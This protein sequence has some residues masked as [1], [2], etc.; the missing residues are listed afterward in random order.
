VRD[1]R[2][3]RVI[4]CVG[5]LRRI[6]QHVTSRKRSTRDAVFQRLALEVLHHEE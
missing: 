3:V 2:L 4:E 5:N 1:L 6:S